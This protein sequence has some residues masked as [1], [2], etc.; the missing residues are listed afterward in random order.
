MT[1]QNLQAGGRYDD[2]PFVIGVDDVAGIDRDAADVDRLIDFG[3]AQRGV[4]DAFA[5]GVH[6]EAGAG[7]AGNVAHPAIAHDADA[8]GAGEDLCHA[9]A[10]DAFVIGPVADGFD[11][12]DGG[13][14]HRLDLLEL[15]PVQFQRDG[16]VR[17]AA[18]EFTGHGNADRW[19]DGRG[20]RL[21]VAAHVIVVRRGVVDVVDGVG[22][23][24]RVEVG[25]FAHQ[26]KKVGGHG[27][28]PVWFG[29]VEVIFSVLRG[30]VGRRRCGRRC[31]PGNSPSS[32]R[33]VRWSGKTTFHH[34]ARRTRRT[35]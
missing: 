16:I 28:F 34:R 3:K 32:H 6:G 23:Q 22:E 4:V 26:L 7:D 5:A 13:Q 1:R 14:F 27:G 18:V 9:V 29:K 31:W 17:G 11:D 2:D 25:E 30:A 8:T 12:P 35:P 21:N 10:D 19:T 24:G 33:S 20:E 15:L